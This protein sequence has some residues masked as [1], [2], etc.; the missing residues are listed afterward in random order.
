MR[1]HSQEENRERPVAG[2]MQNQNQQAAKKDN[3]PKRRE[4]RP[5]TPQELA[6][7][8]T[9]KFYGKLKSGRENLFQ[10]FGDDSRLAAGY[11]GEKVKVCIGQEQIHRRFQEPDYR[12]T[13]TDVICVD[14]LEIGNG[15][16][17]IQTTGLCENVDNDQLRFHESFVLAPQ[18]GGGFYVL[19]NARRIAR[20]TVAQKDAAPPVAAA[21]KPA[22]VT[23]ASAVPKSVQAQVIP[24]KE[25]PAK[26]TMTQNSTA[27]P[28]PAPA[29]AS[30]PPQV[31]S[32]VSA[33][34]AAV[35]R[36]DSK[37]TNAKPARGG[38]Y[39]ANPAP[40]I[41]KPATA[42]EPPSA[43]DSAKKPTKAADAAPAPNTAP[44]VAPAA[45]APP[46]P[47]GAPPS[48]PARHPPNSVPPSA[49]TAPA[50]A[51]PPVRTW[52]SAAANNATASWDK[53]NIA[54]VKGTSTKPSQSP[55][56]ATF[57]QFSSP[58]GAAEAIGKRV[59]LPGGAEVVAEPKKDMRG[60]AMQGSGPG[61]GG[62]GPRGPGMSGRRRGS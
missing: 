35:K 42:A 55:N 31:T 40:E 16:F 48:Q 46:P 2:A 8:F 62:G 20:E 41:A 21:S 10:F 54:E 58:G 6:S 18:N 32:P 60:R 29:A 59:M 36:T 22:G 4:P 49:S 19:A 51:P 43:P 53:K 11:E 17:L 50:A 45:A 28:A 26:P 27:A 23:A 56:T 30:E 3:A 33:G 44:V 15:Q 61:R 38:G 39:V 34:D 7:L 5:L 1:L 47:Q 13:F 37:R 57:V 24:Q 52:A 9:E 25:E 12:I 14:A